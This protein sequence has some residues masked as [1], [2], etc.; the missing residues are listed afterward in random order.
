[1]GQ[2]ITWIS[3]DIERA[4]VSTVE[5]LSD[6]SKLREK[7]SQDNTNS[8]M[9]DVSRHASYSVVDCVPTLVYCLL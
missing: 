4:L 1:M 9:P 6:H 3:R 5:L 7:T 8:H 2:R